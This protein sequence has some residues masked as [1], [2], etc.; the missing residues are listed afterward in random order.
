MYSGTAEYLSST[1][2]LKYSIQLQ[3]EECRVTNS[4]K[5]YYQ[6]LLNQSLLIEVS[7][8]ISAALQVFGGVWY[9]VACSVTTQTT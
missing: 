7:S 2:Y 8:I 1:E 4:D 3:F 6:L 9:Q 5:V